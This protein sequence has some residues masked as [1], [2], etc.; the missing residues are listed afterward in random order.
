MLTPMPARSPVSTSRGEH[1]RE[2]VLRAAESLMA[3]RGYWSTSMVD[4]IRESGVPSSSIYW[5][6]TSKSG[7]L[8]AVMERGA[9]AFFA[10]IAAANPGPD[11]LD[12]RAALEHM[13]RQSAIALADNPSFLALHMNFLLHL[14]EEPAIQA[15]VEGVRRRAMDVIRTHL[16]ASY[17]AY[18]HE[19]AG[20]I[21][22]RV[23]PL[24]L[25]F[26]DG[27]F[28]SLQSS[29]GTDQDQALT[30]VA[31]ALHQVAQGIN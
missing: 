24:A 18:G 17:A 2:D 1:T 20:R 12:P 27:L 19:R 7:V 6:F 29:D 22:A 15:Q 23:A 21:A 28:V 10:S 4:L 30:D 9:S 14:E 3:T 13:L 31:N 25:A 8:A 11:Q 16:A 26:F 5:H